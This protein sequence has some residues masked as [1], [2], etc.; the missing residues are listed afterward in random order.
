MLKK[1]VSNT[2]SKKIRTR[3]IPK[4]ALLYW[5]RYN[6][7]VIKKPDKLPDNIL[8]QAIDAAWEVKERHAIKINHINISHKINADNM[9]DWYIHIVENKDDNKELKR[10]S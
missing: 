4:E 8:M 5:D 6:F 9:S 2:D 1:T 10:D 3:V 7:I